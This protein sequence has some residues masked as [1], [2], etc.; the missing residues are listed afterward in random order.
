MQSEDRYMDDDY[1]EKVRRRVAKSKK[2][3]LF[4]ILIGL[5]VLGG[6]LLMNTWIFRLLAEEG[7]ITGMSAGWSIGCVL[8]I[9]LGMS[10]VF[11]AWN[12]YIGINAWKGP[13]MERLLLNYHDELKRMKSEHRS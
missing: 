3:A 11:A 5:F 8:G 2:K 1:I 6:F 9:M 7:D 10:L 13:R 12:L 4:H